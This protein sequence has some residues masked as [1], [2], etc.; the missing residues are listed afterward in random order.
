MFFNKTKHKDEPSSFM[1]SATKSFLVWL[2]IGVTDMNRAVSF[3]QNV[4]NLKIEI[5]YL[6]DSKL[7]IFFK[8][9][10]CLN[11]CLV[12]R[13]NPNDGTS[14]IKPT[15]HVDV[16][17]ETLNKVENNGGK[18]VLPSTLLRQKNSRGETLIGA[19]LIDNQIGY[20]AEFIDT[21]GNAILLYG[22]C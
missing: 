5:K 19:N 1:G 20:V 18:I 2:E 8:N 22:H 16:I 11:I 14:K 10:Q 21:E 6:F 7:G 12:E 9:D 17:F 15:F 13:E 3:Y 4:F